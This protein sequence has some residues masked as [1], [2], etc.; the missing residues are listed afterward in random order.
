MELK[1][2]PMAEFLLGLMTI[3]NRDAKWFSIGITERSHPKSMEKKSYP[4]AEFYQSNDNT[5]RLWDAESGSP[6]A[7]LKGHIQ[8]V[9]ELKSYPMGILSWSLT[10]HFDCGRN[11]GASVGVLER[12]AHIRCRCCDGRILHG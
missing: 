10:K 6:L 2:Y 5:L 8:R 9:N 11:D 12:H 4:M 7:L 1:S 3:H